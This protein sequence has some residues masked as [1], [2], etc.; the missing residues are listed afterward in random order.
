MQSTMSSEYAAV[1][2]KL[3][4]SN[5]RN[6]TAEDILTS[7]SNVTGAR[8]GN[9]AKYAKFAGGGEVPDN[10]RELTPL[11]KEQAAKLAEELN[12]FSY[13]VALTSPAIRAHLTGV[14]A[15]KG[16]YKFVV[17]PALGV[18]TAPDHALS[19]AFAYSAYAPIFNP[20]YKDPK[21]GN[22]RSYALNDAWVE[23]CSQQAYVMVCALLDAVRGKKAQDVFFAAHAVITPWAFIW[24]NHLLG[25]HEN[26]EAIF[27]QLCKFEMPEACAINMHLNGAGVPSI[28]LYNQGQ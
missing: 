9:A 1:L 18:D 11:G 5:H 28:Q 8:H 7:F 19:L 21:H 4:G 27:E 25:E 15:T 13:D 12:E 3:C 10:L 22:N 24:L 16:K 20:D 23:E 26:A 14:I 6:I 2:K 17:V